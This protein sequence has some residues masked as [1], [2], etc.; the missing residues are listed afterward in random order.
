MVKKLS[1]EEKK[2][3]YEEILEILKSYEEGL[4]LKKSE[5]EFEF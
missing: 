2:D 4:P 1:K 3:P 5:Q